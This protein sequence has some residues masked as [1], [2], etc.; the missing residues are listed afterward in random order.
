MARE[1]ETFGSAPTDLQFEGRYYPDKD[2][3]LPA[4]NMALKIVPESEDKT[5]GTS[6]G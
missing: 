4:P 1:L 6:D 3:G 2:G 5:T